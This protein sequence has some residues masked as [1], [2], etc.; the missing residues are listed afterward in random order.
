MAQAAVDLGGRGFSFGGKTLLS[1]RDPD[2]AARRAADAAPLSEGTLFLCPS[3]L[4]GHGLSRLLARIEASAGCALLCVEAEDELRALSREKI[5]HEIASRELFRLTD[6]VGAEE[7]CAF[8]RREWGARAFRRVEVARLNGGWQLHRELYEG[9]AQAL[10]REIALDWGNALTM[11]ALGRGYAKNALRN[12]ARAAGG[13]SLKALS[14]GSCPTL[15]LGAGPSM[16]GALDALAARFGESLRDPELRPFR[17]V[18]ADTCLPALKARGLRP[19]LAVV[20]ESQFWNVG[21]FVGLSGWDVP[22]AADLSALPRTAEVLSGG[23]RFFFTRWAPL[24][25][26]D[27]LKA[28]DFLPPEMPALGSVG[29]SA[30][31]IALALCD[32]P[33][34]VSGLDFSFGIDLSHARSSPRHLAVLRQWNRFSG[35]ALARSAFSDGVFPLEPEQPGANL[36]STGAMRGYRELFD[37]EFGSHE[38]LSGF[39]PSDERALRALASGAPRIRAT[40]PAPRPNG[41]DLRLFAR[42]ELDALDRLRAEISAEGAS[43]LAEPLS[44]CDYLWAHFPDAPRRAADLA[45]LC[46][47]RCDAAASFFRRVLAEIGPFAA[48]WE[49]LGAGP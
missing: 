20:L 7:L 16:D 40:I 46:A 6:C 12:L 34:F 37:R 14:F 5:P 32:G 4:F 23:A 28:Q 33:V 3:P 41:D 31:A 24:R 21:D 17:I 19:D 38:R 29:L 39:S 44:E 1:G 2:A 27:R 13:P 15:V 30:L 8:V 48:L 43:G 22:V 47:S 49:R 18:C 25:L 11:A 42:A 9:M 45:G 36:R 10:R 26:F 35:I